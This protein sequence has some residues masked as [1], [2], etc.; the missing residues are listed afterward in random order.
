MR[1]KAAPALVRDGSTLNLPRIL[2]LNTNDKGREKMNLEED[3]KVSR[4]LYSHSLEEV[5]DLLARYGFG[6]IKNVTELLVT[7]LNSTAK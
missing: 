4:T 3:R 2:S 5:E 1:A 7:R 6:Y